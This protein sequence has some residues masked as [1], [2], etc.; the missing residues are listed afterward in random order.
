MTEDPQ[1]FKNKLE[2]TNIIKRITLIP[3]YSSPS[4]YPGN[5]DEG[6]GFS[7]SISIGTPIAILEEQMRQ[8]GQNKKRN[9][10]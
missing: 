9:G 4:G 6:K 7:S 8:Q 5:G 3:V 1:R 10:C 2:N